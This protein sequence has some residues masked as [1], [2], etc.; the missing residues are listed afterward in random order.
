M[1]RMFSMK[2]GSAVEVLSVITLNPSWFKQLIT[3]L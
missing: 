3:E 2:V 1:I